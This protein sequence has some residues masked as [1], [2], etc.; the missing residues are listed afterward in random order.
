MSLRQFLF[1]VESRSF[2]GKRWLN[3]IFRSVH[4]CGMGVYTGGVFF[5]VAQAAVMPSYL[6]TAFSGLAIMGMDL[7]GNFKFVFQNRGAFILV[8]LVLLGMLPHFPEYQK[9]GL[10]GI[11]VVSSVISHATANFRYYSLFHRKQI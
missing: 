7:F 6:V 4:L 9:W 8:K 10:L 3:V 2:W 5:G 1:P 11:I